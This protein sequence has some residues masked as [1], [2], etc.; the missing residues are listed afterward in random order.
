MWIVIPPHGPY[1]WVSRSLL[2]QAS[3]PLRSNS[4]R[5]GFE[6]TELH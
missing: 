6:L 4:L 5:R 1:A 3:P 2:T